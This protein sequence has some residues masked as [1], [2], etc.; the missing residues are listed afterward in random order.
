ML[1]RI[2]AK[3]P[4][5]ARAFA[6][7]CLFAL[8]A[9]CGDEIPKP[10][11][12]YHLDFPAFPE[13]DPTTTE[14]LIFLSSA[15]A[16]VRLLSAS[17]GVR[18]YPT[19]GG[20][21][22]RIVP[23]FAF[24][25]RVI[26]YLKGSG[27]DELTV[28]VLAEDVDPRRYAARAMSRAA[29]NALPSPTPNPSIALM[30]AQS[31]LGE[32]DTRWDDRE[33]IVFLR[34]SPIAGEAGVYEFANRSGRTPGLHNYAVS[35][36][37]EN[38]YFPNRAWL[39]RAAPDSS[40]S[41][42]PRYLAAAPDSPSAPVISLSEMKALVAADADMT[43]K[44]EGVPGYEDCV[45]TKFE[46][47]A[48]YKNRPPEMTSREIRI[49]SG[50]SAGYRIGENAPYP[51]DPAPYY[52]RWWF[53]GGDSDLFAVRIVDDPDNDPATGYST[54]DV[55]LRPLPAGE[56]K[57]F[58]NVQYSDW[59][60]CDYNP[61]SLMNRH[62]TTIIATAPDDIVHEAFFDPAD[63][64]NGAV[65]ADGG[66]GV[67]APKSFALGG[68][69]VSIESIRWESQAVEM[70]L[71]PHARLANHRA[72][73]IA[74]DGSVVLRLNFAD[75]EETGEG[76]SRAFRWTV[77]AKPWSGGDALM[78]RI[79]ESRPAPSLAPSPTAAP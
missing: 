77:R 67:L 26:E 6:V 64:A 49:P 75:A 8:P 41:S 37:Y 27:G 47:D 69:S 56:Y 46:Y 59:V 48:L 17:P 58:Y 62:E 71:S 74:L 53:A 18:R 44:G 43:A 66:G 35:S 61:E 31:A 4:A 9:A 11:Q 57:V 28:R 38:S 24:R 25:F 23:V 32:R 72:D 78:L 50:R 20:Y 54:E 12:P 1:N 45:R 29:S 30:L 63:M 76:D 65:G 70:R 19:E 33:A 68:A 15:V 10:A 16:R 5:I 52:E 7:A 79:G 51:H 3:L 2:A 14:E 60:P 34:P 39:P 55:A 22:G 42:E 21:E 73:F 40:S 36:D 13:Q